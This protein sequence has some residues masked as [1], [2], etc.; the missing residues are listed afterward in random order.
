MPHRGTRDEAG[1]PAPCSCVVLKRREDSQRARRRDTETVCD[2]GDADI[3]V[4]QHRL[5]SLDVFIGEFSRTTS[6]AA[7][8]AS[9]GESRLGALP[10]QAAL[11][12]RIMRSS[13]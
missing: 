1:Q 12:F 3:G 8:A 11:E 6:G 2:L 5:G 7:C 13:A 9:G 10:D 4:G